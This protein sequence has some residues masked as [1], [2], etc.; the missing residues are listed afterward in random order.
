LQAN[1]RALPF[2]AQFRAGIGAEQ[3]LSSEQRNWRDNIASAWAT[4]SDDLVKVRRNDGVPMRLD[5]DQQALIMSR[6]ELQL[7]IAQQAALNHYGDFYLVTLNDLLDTL[8][9]FFALEHSAVVQMRGELEALRALPVDPDY[10][11]GL[12]SHAMLRDRISEIRNA[13]AGE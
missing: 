6:M 12:I 9:S 10:P 4:L 11:T 8:T 3:E 5:L 7:Q 2:A 1:V 13:N